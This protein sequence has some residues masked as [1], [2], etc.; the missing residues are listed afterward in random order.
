MNSQKD[1]SRYDRQTILQGFGADGQQKLTEARVLVIGAGGLGCPALQYLV[2]SG[3]GN[4]GIVDDDTVSL[5]NLHRQILFTSD[6][7]GLPKVEVASRR[8]HQMNPDVTITAY[9]VRMDVSNALDIISSHDIVLDG[10][11]NFSSRYLINDACALLEKPLVFGA[12]SQ[13]EGQVSVFNVPDGNNDISNYRD[14]FPERPGD[15]EIPNCAQAGVLGVLPGI[16]GTMQ[17]AEVI[18]L[19]TGLGTPLAGK[20]LTFNLLNNLFYEV[21]FSSSPETKSLIPV[22]KQEFEN[23]HYQQSCGIDERSVVEIDAQQLKDLLLTPS[24]LVIDVRA[25]N[26]MPRLKGFE[27]LVVPMPRFYNEIASIDAH[28][29]ILVCQHG[30]RSMYAA[31]LLQEENTEIKRLYSLK[32]GVSRWASDLDL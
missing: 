5:S 12:V 18:K 6:D 20:L 30:I 8:L 9:P 3:V 10:T 14:L 26:E 27:H 15:N 7:I 23:M 28:N 16:V 24:T 11:D 2:A 22:D 17:A 21:A 19:I 4:I 32:G 31:E 25:E 13:F 29:V 1:F